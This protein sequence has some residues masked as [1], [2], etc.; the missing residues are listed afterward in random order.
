MVRA[1]ATV[2]PFELE[3][4]L[5]SVQDFLAWPDA[6]VPE[7]RRRRLLDLL[8]L[9]GT[10]VAVAVVRGGTRTTADLLTGLTARWGI[11][12]VL[13]HVDDVFVAGADRVRASAAIATLEELVWRDAER[14]TPA[15]RPALVRLRAEL[16]RVRLEPAMRQVELASGLADVARGLLRLDEPDLRALTALATGRDDATRLELPPD[17]DARRIRGTADVRIH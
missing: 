9:H 1:L 17:A 15:D 16:D 13:T 4:A 11:G 10:S 5:L 6:P 7:G 14:C 8:G 3:D 12:A 2:D